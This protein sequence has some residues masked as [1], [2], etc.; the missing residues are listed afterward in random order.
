MCSRCEISHR[1]GREE[2]EGKED[3]VLDNVKVRHSIE[4]KN[5]T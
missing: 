3:R 2:R 5:L 1:E 4:E